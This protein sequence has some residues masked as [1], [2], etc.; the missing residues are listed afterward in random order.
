MKKKYWK[1]ALIVV[2]TILVVSLISVAIEIN[3]CHYLTTTPPPYSPPDYI[4]TATLCDVNSNVAI[5]G[6]AIIL[7]WKAIF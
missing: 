4:K 7:L 1:T 3:Y 6:I 2:L 5:P